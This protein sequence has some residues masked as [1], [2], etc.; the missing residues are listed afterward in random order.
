[1][2]ATKNNKAVPLG[3][4]LPLSDAMLD[5]MAKVTTADQVKA[6]ELWRNS[7][8]AEFKTLLDAETVTTDI[9]PKP[10]TKGAA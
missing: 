3:K 10:K 5:E 7:A 9:Q 1:M 6:A 2:A 4:P 8:P